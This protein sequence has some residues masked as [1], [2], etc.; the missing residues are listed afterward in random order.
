MKRTSP[1]VFVAAA[2][3]QIAAF[4]IAVWAMERWLTVEDDARDDEHRE[5]LAPAPPT[6]VRVVMPSAEPEPV[7]AAEPEPAAA[8]RFGPPPAQAPA[9]TSSRFVDPAGDG[10]TQILTGLAGDRPIVFGF[11]ADGTI[12][13]VDTDGGRYEGRSENARARMREIDGTRAFTVQIGVAGDGRLTAA[14][15]GGA[16]ADATI[17]LER[18]VD[19]S[20]A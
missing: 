8:P 3:V 13:F 7:R 12:R 15:Y 17:R 4:G 10:S 11:A 2:A 5:A 9:P 19:G 20:I 1:W 6:V 14:F 18:A 16:H